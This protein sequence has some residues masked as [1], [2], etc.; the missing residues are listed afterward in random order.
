MIFISFPFCEGRKERVVKSI[1]I[2]VEGNYLGRE[3]GRKRE[4]I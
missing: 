4:W 2:K 1:L 3:W